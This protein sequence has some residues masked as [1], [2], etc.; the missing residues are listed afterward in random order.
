[1]SSIF[2]PRL[3]KYSLR[4]QPDFLRN[5]VNSSKYDL[6]SKRFFASTNGS[7]EIKNLKSLEDFKNKIRRWE[8]DG[9]D[10]NLCKDFFV[11]F[12]RNFCLISSVRK[13]LPYRHL[14]SLSQHGQKTAKCEICT[15]LTMM[16][17]KHYQ[18]C[19]SGVCIVGI[20]PVSRPRLVFL[21]LVLSG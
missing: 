12:K 19:C 8:S 20:G 21:L 5:P 10:C 4:T 17:T 13:C 16:A 15:E 6:N 2:P 18:W 11:K 3:I 1:M 14:A 9:W 7:N